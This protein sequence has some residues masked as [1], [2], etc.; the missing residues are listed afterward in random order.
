MSQFSDILVVLG[1]ILV[2]DVKSVVN[3]A[4]GDIFLQLD[5]LGLV[6]LHVHVLDRLYHDYRLPAITPDVV[7]VLIPLLAE[8]ELCES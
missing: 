3:E 1:L 7:I 5:D 4:A 6:L 2:R 8:C